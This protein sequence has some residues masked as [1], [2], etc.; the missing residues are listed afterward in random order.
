MKIKYIIAETELPVAISPSFSVE[1]DEGIS[2]L[3]LE[4]YLPYI[5]SVSNFEEMQ[6]VLNKILV[7]KQLPETFRSSVAGLINIKREELGLIA[8]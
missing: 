7:E 1:L 4:E 6:A 2:A 3:I 8:F 5:E